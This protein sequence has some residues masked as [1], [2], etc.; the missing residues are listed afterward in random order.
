MI[1]SSIGKR[2]LKDRMQA[3]RNR[4]INVTKVHRLFLRL[5]AGVGIAIFRILVLEYFERSDHINRVYSLNIENFTAQ[6]VDNCLDYYEEI[7]RLASDK[8]GIFY[9][10]GSD[11]FLVQNICC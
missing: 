3:D 8:D 7:K 5:S 9:I 4:K 11:E 1:L 6:F 2:K 10:V